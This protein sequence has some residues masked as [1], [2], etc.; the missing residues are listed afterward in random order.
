MGC[1]PRA[2]QNQKEKIQHKSNPQGLEEEKCTRFFFCRAWS[3]QKHIIS[4]YSNQGDSVTILGVARQFYGRLHDIKP[5]D[6]ALMATILDDVDRVT[7]G[8]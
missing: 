3:K 7:E 1:G 4:L 5:T 8:G 2:G 6:E